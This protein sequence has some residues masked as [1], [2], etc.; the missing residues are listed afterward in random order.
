MHIDGELN[1]D[2]HSTNTVSIGKPGIVKCE[3]AAHKLVVAGKFS[4]NADC[5]LIEVLAG[6]EVDGQLTAA[7]LAIDGGGAFQ[8]QS[9]RK[10][11]SDDS[12]KVVDFAAEAKPR[13]DASAS[14]SKSS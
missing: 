1:G 7:S 14:D 9:I 12:T 4:G 3:L 6:G 13:K 2:I 8:G 5:E 10:K 11:P